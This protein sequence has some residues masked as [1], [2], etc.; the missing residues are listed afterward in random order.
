MHVFVIL[1]PE[2]LFK[3]NIIIVHFLVCV[4]G[5][6]IHGSEISINVVRDTTSKLELECIYKAD[7]I[8]Y[9]MSKISYNRRMG[10]KI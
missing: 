5:S 1:E 2:A 8:R 3:M 4:L 9:I 7:L 6:C 10:G